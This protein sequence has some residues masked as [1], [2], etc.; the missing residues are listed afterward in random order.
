M[1]K[2]GLIFLSHKIE[3]HVT[4]MLYATKQYIKKQGNILL[5]RAQICKSKLKIIAFTACE[6]LCLAVNARENSQ[7]WQ[8]EQTHT[9]QKFLMLLNINSL[10]STAVSSYKK[11]WFNKY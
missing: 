11:T 6:L 2:L 4:F 7:S 8:N 3:R 1:N 9:K 5:S 10:K